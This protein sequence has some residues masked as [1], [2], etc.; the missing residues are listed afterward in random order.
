[1]EGVQEAAP[2]PEQVLLCVKGVEGVQE[3]APPLTKCCV[4]TGCGR[5]AEG[6]T[7][8]Q[9]SVVVYVKGVEGVQE[10]APSP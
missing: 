10:A 5:S 3:V 6:S 9:A 7:L 1:M 4:F 8:T 2:S